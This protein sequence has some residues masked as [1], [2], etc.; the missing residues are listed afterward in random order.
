MSH[1]ISLD[2]KQAF[3]NLDISKTATI[4]SDLGVSKALINRIIVA[5]LH[6]TTSIQ[7]FGQ[8]T[9]S[10]QKGRGVKQ[11]CPLSPELFVLLLHHALKSINEF[12]PDIT[13]VQGTDI[14]LPCI[15]GYAD[16]LLFLCRNDEDVEK[17]LSVLEPILASIG[18]ELNTLK[19]KVLIRD[20]YY[21]NNEEPDT[22]LTFGKY[23]LTT[24]TKLRYLG[25][26]I[27][28]SL[29][30][31]ETTAER[32]KKA[33]KAFYSLCSFLK[34]HK[35]KWSVVVKLYHSLI[36][37][38]VTYS[39]E[40]ATIL[41]RNRNS[42]RRME[43]H[44]LQVLKRLS[45]A[46]D[47]RSETEYEEL[48]H[49]SEDHQTSSDTYGSTPDRENNNMSTHTD[50]E[51]ENIHVAPKWLKGKTINNKIRI[52]RLNY[53][54]HILRSENKGILKTALEYKLPMKKKMGRPAFT[55]RTNIRQDI[56]RSKIHITDWQAASFDRER[57]KNMTRR[58]YDEMVESEYEE[59]S[60]IDEDSTGSS[61]IPSEFEGFSE[62]ESLCLG[63]DFEREESN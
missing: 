44:M 56:D 54:G 28:S 1:H 37:P 20:P 35:L 52:N 50:S 21:V 39:M 55:W 58:L 13:L 40:V 7:W 63:L 29:T 24:V 47:E 23:K 41:K 32:K 36:T 25:A 45:L 43:N 11:G 48:I 34:D 62:N 2:L 12:L 3:D 61:L 8:K 9:H 53:Y 30:R 38:V 33:Y 14:K 15:L 46:D 19:S 16:D 4:L 42:L 60:D 31:R 26:Y 5:C 18:L 27:T 17:L 59:D 22:I 57:Y 10:V 49:E 6:E 51:V